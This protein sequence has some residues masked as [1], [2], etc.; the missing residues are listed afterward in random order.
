VVELNGRPAKVA[1]ANGPLRSSPLK[2][3]TADGDAYILPLSAGTV[4]TNAVQERYAK[5]RKLAT[6]GFVEKDPPPLRQ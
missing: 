2:V 5:I 6:R 1:Q 3:N 4:N